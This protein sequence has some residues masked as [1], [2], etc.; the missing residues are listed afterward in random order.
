MPKDALLAILEPS[1]PPQGVTGSFPGCMRKLEVQ[2]RLLVRPKVS[3][4]VT[5]CSQKVESGTFFGNN[6]SHLVLC[7]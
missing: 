5:G 4:G 3:V 7:E 1:R 6:G 2:D